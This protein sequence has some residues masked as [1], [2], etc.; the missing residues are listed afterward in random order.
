MSFFQINSE[1]ERTYKISS[2]HEKA[3]TARLWGS[4]YT[5]QLVVAK[6]IWNYFLLV[7]GDYFIIF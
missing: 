4:E 3:E 5:Y 1:N 7:D 2:S 6:Q